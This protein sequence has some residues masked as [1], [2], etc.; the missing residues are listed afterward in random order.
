MRRKDCADESLRRVEKVVVGF[1]GVKD[2]M[3]CCSGSVMSC[4]MLMEP[5]GRGAGRMT[6]GDMVVVVMVVLLCYQDRVLTLR[7]VG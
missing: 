2:V 6:E 4:P 3:S 5:V 7:A 1:E